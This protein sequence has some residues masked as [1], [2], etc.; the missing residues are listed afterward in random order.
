M[1][2]VCKTGVVVA[3]GGCLVIFGSSVFT[4]KTLLQIGIFITL[5]GIVI[6]IIGAFLIWREHYDPY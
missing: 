4:S 1:S 2:K 6:Q 3:I 5:S